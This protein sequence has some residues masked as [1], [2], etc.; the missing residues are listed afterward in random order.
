MKSRG[1]RRLRV[2]LAQLPVQSHDF[3]YSRENHPLAVALVA[4]WA[5]RSHPD[6]EIDLLPA[7]LANDGGDAA[8]LRALVGS[9]PDVV[10]LGCAVWNLER[11][12]ALA[13]ALKRRRPRTLIV[14]GGPEIALDNEFLRE[15]GGFDVAVVGEGE[16]AFSDLLE[17][18][19]AGSPLDRVPGLLLP[20][21]WRL[22]AA[23]AP[24]EPLSRLPSPILEGL[25]APSSVRSLALE[26]VR[27]CP[28]RCAYCHYHK[29]FPRL[30]T[31][32]LERV[33][34]ELRTARRRGA[35]ELT[36]VDP[37][38]LRRPELGP[39]LKTLERSRLEFRAELNAED[40]TPG[41]A[42]S[43]AAAR[44][45]EVEVGLQ[46]VNPIALRLAQRG[47]RREA[48]VAGVRRLR[49]EGI[50]VALDVMVGLPGDSL[51]DVRRSVA[52]AV[53]NDL[54]D[55]LKVYPLCVLPGTVF[56][57]RA[58]ELGIVFEREPP[59]HVLRTATMSEEDIDAALVAAE[60]LAGADLFPVEVPSVRER[61]V[62]KHG[63]PI[64]KLDPADVRQAIR[65]DLAGRDWP[66]RLP[67]L[68]RALRPA[69][70]DNP[71]TLVDWMLP[72]EP[73]PEA[74]HLAALEAIAP[75]AP[76]PIDRDWF[77][78]HDPRRSIQTFVTGRGAKVRLPSLGAA[79]AK[80]AC[81]VAFDRPLSEPE[82]DALVDRLASRFEDQP[83]VWFRV[84]AA[85]R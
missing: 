37:C 24:I 14:L 8:L 53:E 20:G 19:K 60:D 5:R 63:E 45:R 50:R 6:A 10:G 49:G 4:A 41:L 67:E 58:T 69:L 16:A 64:P 13:R 28:L 78:T 42:R 65:I 71:Y 43:L 27:G 36:F 26:S 12:L 30:R 15:Q 62:V 68:R 25:L 55:D 2:L 34:A 83:E 23:R 48:F 33:E 35:R 7:R 54:F 56:R 11:T 57:R 75:R 40:V 47:F 46:T 79:S 73:F 82:Q 59:Y 61:L 22:T 3:A 39:F 44:L 31:F 84:G 80:R 38:F 81:W 70:A 9:R 21:R 18:L 74:R 77:A 51:A 29:S 1:R 66:S 17:A 85:G 52:F 76:H 72:L 32:P